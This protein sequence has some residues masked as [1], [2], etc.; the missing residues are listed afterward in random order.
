MKNIK[1]GKDYENAYY[2]IVTYKGNP[3]R[4]FTYRT[5]EEAYADG[6]RYY[7]RLEEEDRSEHLK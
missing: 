1:V 3:H 6:V 2:V 4:L 5:K 7:K